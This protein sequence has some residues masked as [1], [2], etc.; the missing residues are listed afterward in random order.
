MHAVAPRRGGAGLMDE[1][2]CTCLLLLRLLASSC[3]A[4]THKHAISAVWITTNLDLLSLSS[5]SSAQYRLAGGGLVVRMAPQRFLSSAS[6][7]LVHW[8]TERR[9]SLSARALSN[10]WLGP[11]WGSTAGWAHQSTSLLAWE[12]EAL[13]NTL[14]NP[15][16]INSLC[17]SYISHLWMELK[18]NIS[19]TH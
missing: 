16:S 7:P 15:C 19:W 6:T 12:T 10:I 5:K 14:R 17:I 3:K 1:Q 9:S 8:W 11:T 2:R 4:N 18:E 13:T